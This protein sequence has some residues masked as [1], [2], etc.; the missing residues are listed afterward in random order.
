MVELFDVTGRRISKLVEEEFEAGA[1]EFPLNTD[2]LAAGN[3]L[4]RLTTETSQ[5]TLKL[6]VE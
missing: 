4:L 1:Y 5:S 6:V 2:Q 3:Y